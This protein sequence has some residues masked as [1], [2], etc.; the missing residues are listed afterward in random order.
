M[1]TH[2]GRANEGSNNE[3]QKKGK[4]AKDNLIGDP[5]IH[6]IQTV[7]ENDGQK[8]DFVD[9]VQNVQR[10]VEETPEC[11]NRGSQRQRQLEKKN[12]GRRGKKE[13]FLS[14]RREDGP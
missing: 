8:G 14:P 9:Y 10:E 6:G 11:E 1:K 5:G 4:T 13:K 12:K 7:A 2:K 3:W